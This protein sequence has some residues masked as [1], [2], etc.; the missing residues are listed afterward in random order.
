MWALIA[1]ILIGLGVMVAPALFNFNEIAANNN[2]IVG[3]LV[4]T[5][6]IVALWEINRNVRFFNIVTGAWLILSPFIIGF[7]SVARTV[8]IVCGIAIIFLS[9][10]KATVKTRYGGGWRSLF[11]KNPLHIQAVKSNSFKEET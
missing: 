2:H 3:P 8:D 4:L 1:N 6:A 10:I 7:T 9:L 5:F 11:Q